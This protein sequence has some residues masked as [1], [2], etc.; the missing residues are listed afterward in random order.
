MLVSVTI[1]VNVKVP[2]D[3]GVPDRTPVLELIVIHEG[4][5]DNYH[6]NGPVPDTLNLTEYL[7][8]TVPSEIVGTIIEGL[9]EGSLM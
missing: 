8:P 4:L 7:T 9:V 3:V 2:A 1:T 5:S 6:V